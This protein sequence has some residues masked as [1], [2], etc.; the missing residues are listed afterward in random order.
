MQTLLNI[1]HLNI[2]RGKKAICS[3]LSFTLQHGEIIVVLGPNG[4]GKSSLLLA[5]AGLISSQGE[6]QVLGKA[7]AGYSNRDLMQQLA[8]QGD[9]PPTEFGLTVQ[10]RLSLVVVEAEKN[11]SA[12]AQDMEIAHLLMRPLQ[13]LSSGERQRV[14]LAALMLR[15]VPIWLL[16]EPTTHLDLKHQ[17]QTVKMLKKH[18]RE[19]RAMVVILHD[20][21]QAMALADALILMD[22]QGGVQY[23]LA[24]A[25]WDKNRLACLFDAPLLQ[26]N[27]ILM[28]D[29]GENDE[30]K[31]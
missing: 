1:S 23:G 31:R 25:L 22:G 9:L 16:D 27:S 5:L 15:D 6:L 18:A 30:I 13:A 12:V 11:I 20:M 26:N 3:D 10:Q 21:Q 28:A 7:L 29:Y 17:I 2:Q 8:W 19:G 14:E 24:E 4:A